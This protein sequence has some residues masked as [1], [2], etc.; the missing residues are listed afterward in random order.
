ML[1]RSIIC[2]YLILNFA[3][4][5]IQSGLYF[6]NAKLHRSKI[7]NSRKSKVDQKT[8][9]NRSRTSRM[10]D[11]RALNALN[12]KHTM[13][14]IMS[15]IKSITQRYLLELKAFSSSEFEK[16]FI[17]ATRPNDDPPK[18]KYVSSIV[19]TVN[20]F[21]SNRLKIKSSN[22]PYFIALH[23]LWLRIVFDDKRTSIKAVYI[24][25]RILQS[26]NIDNVKEFRLR[27]NKMS[28]QVYCK[29]SDSNYFDKQAIRNSYT[30]TVTQDYKRFCVSYA[31]YVIFNRILFYPNFE[32]Y[33]EIASVNENDE[34]G[35]M[36]YMLSL[37][38]IVTK[39]LKSIK[40]L[41][42]CS[43]IIINEVTLPS[44]ELL[45]RDLETLYPLFESKLNDF[46]KGL[47]NII[48]FNVRENQEKLTGYTIDPQIIELSEINVKSEN[49]K[50]I[51]KKA[52]KLLKSYQSMFEDIQDWKNS[53]GKPLRKNGYKSATF[54]MGDIISKS[55]LQQYFEILSKFS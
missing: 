48:N 44:L 50:K 19:W 23:K 3:I 12:H 7:I 14:T 36:L 25:H 49:V 15:D 53:Y 46:L 24:L 10:S 16:A 11:S 34:K 8:K 29:N 37:Y 31:N 1:L 43:P 27:F 17:K 30:N 22:D 47:Q 32:D 38:R 2:Y 51:V 9:R 13:S 21:S 26:T 39:G 6:I 45:C 18:E 52:L 20:E 55:N 35:Y 40:S 28:E 41:I 33:L 5:D 42:S 54:D 4:Y